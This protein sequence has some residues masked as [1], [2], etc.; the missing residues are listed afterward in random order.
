MPLQK[1]VLAFA[2]ITV[3][4]L[5]ACAGDKDKVKLTG[6]RTALHSADAV[7]TPD[8]ALTKTTITLPSITNNA[9][10]P[11][12]VAPADHLALAAKPRPVWQKSIGSGSDRRH[13]LTA[14]PVVADGIVYTLASEGLVTARKLANGAELWRLKMWPKSARNYAGLSGGLAVQQDTLYIA[15]GMPELVALDAK[16]G[17]L[18][19]RTALSAP[20]RTA[21]TIYDDYVV[22][23][24]RDQQTRALAKSDGHMLWQHNGDVET[25]QLA[26]S[27]SALADNSGV[28]VQYP[29]GDIV[30]I[31][32]ENGLVAWQDNLKPAQAVQ[33]QAEVIADTLAAPVADRDVVI[34]STLAGQTTAYARRL[35]DPLWQIPVALNSTPWLAGDWFFAVST[36]GQL[37]AASR[38]TGQIKWQTALPNHVKDDVDTAIRWQGPVLA[39]NRLWLVNNQEE[40][41]TFDAKT[42]QQLSKAKLPSIPALPPIIAKQTLLIL[43]SNGDLMAL[44]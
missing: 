44:R 4:G 38:K 10:W 12:M 34:A 36:D 19:W 18:Q 33:A 3:L 13:L 41:V 14:E 5:S 28:I 23:I 29:A 2:F 16:I 6:E 22:V 31:Q 40:L 24:T 8:A 30:S 27:P 15:T 32:P 21:P 37:F 43:L 1:F 9:D 35:G 7:L 20:A 25:T 17:K 26:L 39:N 11:Q 42:G